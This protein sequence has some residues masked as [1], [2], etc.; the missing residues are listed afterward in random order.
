MEQVVGRVERIS[1]SLISGWAYDGRQVDRP[2]EVALV[3]NG[4]VVA[5]AL[6]DRRREDL[7]GIGLGRDDIAFD[8]PVPD[9]CILRADDIAVVATGT[10]ETLPVDGNA[11][12]N[13]G[14]VEAFQDHTA[15]GWAW[16]TGLSKRVPLQLI[17]QDTVLHM[18]VADAY[19]DDLRTNGIGDGRHGF[20]VNF[21]HLAQGTFDP[22]AYDIVFADTQLPLA[23]LHPR[24]PVARKMP[25]P[26]RPMRGPQRHGTE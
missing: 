9:G 2:V 1:R 26:L 13:E 19:R 12:V 7:T 16:S 6:A 4:E 11:F 22:T 3:L 23:H 15:R 5:R 24:W 10:A 17:R 21:R 8:L 20:S 14:I 18:F 25:L